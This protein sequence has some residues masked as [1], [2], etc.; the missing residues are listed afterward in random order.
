[1]DM[2]DKLQR[3]YYHARKITQKTTTLTEERQ[4]IKEE[5]AP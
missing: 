5:V 1:M 2:I 3:I 4:K